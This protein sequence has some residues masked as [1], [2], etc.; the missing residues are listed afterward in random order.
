MTSGKAGSLLDEP[1][2][3]ADKTVN[4]LERVFD[5]L[6]REAPAIAT[7]AANEIVDAT[8]I[9]QR[10]PLIGRPVDNLCELEISKGRT[11]YVA[12]YRYLPEQDRVDI[13]ASRHLGENGLLD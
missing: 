6:T 1:L 5:F 12:L 3:E 11:G 13:L 9:L 2:K 8:R 4:R 7:E 10:H